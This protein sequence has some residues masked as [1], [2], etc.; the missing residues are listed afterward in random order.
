M[1]VGLR[2]RFYRVLVPDR[3]KVWGYGM[4]KKAKPVLF[5]LSV[6]QVEAIANERDAALAELVKLRAQAAKLAEA[7]RVQ[8]ECYQAVGM[9]GEALGCGENEDFI[10]LQDMLAYGKTEDGKELLPF[11][12]LPNFK[13]D[14]A[15]AEL[16]KLREENE[17][18]RKPALTFAGYDLASGPSRTSWGCTCGRRAESQHDLHAG[19]PNENCP[20]R[21]LPAPPKED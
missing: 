7:E 4:S 3:E 15:H 17:R 19:C 16:A 1:N 2:C 18:L 13:A 21:P 12:L 20:G 9:L 8:A 6:T 11:P 10:R 14:A 5:E